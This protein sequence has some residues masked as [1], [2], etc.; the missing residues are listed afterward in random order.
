M[1]MTQ[2]SLAALAVSTLV[3]AGCGG[4][5]KPMAVVPE[6]VH[7]SQTSAIKKIEAEGLTAVPR[8]LHST[9]TAGK[10]LAVY[11]AA[12]S[13]VTKGSTVEITI[14]D[15]KSPNDFPTPPPPAVEP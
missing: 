14:S 15:G 13:R 5:S 10:V 12:G 7:L 9:T 1:R 6:V 4:S 2:S 8:T 11:P 3:L